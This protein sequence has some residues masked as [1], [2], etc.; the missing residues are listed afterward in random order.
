VPGMMFVV[1]IVVVIVMAVIGHAQAQK[2]RKDLAAWAAAR[3][4]EFSPDRM[5]GVDDRFPGFEALRRGD[6]RYA[7]NILSGRRNGAEFYAFD[8]HYETHSRDSK[9]RR[10][11]N[12]HH[13]SAVILGAPVPLQSLAI[14]PEGF[15]DRVGAFFGYE[16]INFESAEFSRKFHVSAPDRRWAYDVLHARAIEFLLASPFY[17]IDMEP[18]HVLALRNAVFPPDEFETAARVVEG[19]LERLP[20]YVKQR[21]IAAPPPIPGVAADDTPATPPPPLPPPVPLA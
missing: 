1:V 12:H 2:R 13:F 3:G 21:Q 6:N 16:D 9:G 8:Y 20:D 19:L 11:T 7:H 5:G 18:T 17:T 14:R 10:R 15:F 4:L